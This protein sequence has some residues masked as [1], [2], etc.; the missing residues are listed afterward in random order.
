MKAMR[1]L[2]CVR[3]EK[4]EAIANE[5]KRR[6]W[7]SVDSEDTASL[8]WSNLVLLINMRIMSMTRNSVNLSLIP[9][10]ISSFPNQAKID[11]H[12]ATQQKNIV[13]HFRGSQHLS[14]KVSRYYEYVVS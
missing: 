12:S 6:G 13:N 10:A 14:N 1:G 4:F 2:F 3:D 11:F 8:I 7:T 5:L 9:D